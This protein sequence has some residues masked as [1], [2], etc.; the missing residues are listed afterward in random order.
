MEPGLRARVRAG[1]PAAFSTLF[2]E[3]SRSVYNLAFRLTGNWSIAEEAVSLTFLEAWRLRASVEPDGGSLRPWLLGIA[4]NVN[5][6]MSRAARRH[7]AALSRL[8]P[9]PPVPDFADD[10]AGQLDDARQLRRVLA[11]VDGLRADERDVIALCVWSELDYAA[12]AKALGVPAGTVRSR[13]SRARRKLRRL[14]ADGA[15]PDGPDG[16]PRA[17]CEQLEG[18]RDLAAR[19]MQEGTR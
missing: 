13:L 1:D 11:A 7:Q 12:A 18:D 2:D 16:E 19:P 6:N 3:H 15:A 4:I 17:R 9:P 5:R 10:L 8:P 14:A